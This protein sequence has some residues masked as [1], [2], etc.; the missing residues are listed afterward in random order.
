MGFS[1][2]VRFR[3]VALRYPKISES[4]SISVGGMNLLI[5]FF[6]SEYISVFYK[7]MIK[8]FSWRHRLQFL[9]ALS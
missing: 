8:M 7:L 4:E 5:L 1:G 6:C 3:Y 9:L 2:S